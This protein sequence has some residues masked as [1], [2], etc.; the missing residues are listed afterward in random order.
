MRFLVPVGGVVDAYG[1]ITAPNHKGIPA[2]IKAGLPWAADVGCLDGPAYVKRINWQALIPWLKTMEPYRAQ[3]LFIA[4]GDIVADAAATLEAYEEVTRYFGHWPAAYVIQNG[5]ENL[6]IPDDC[7][8]VFLGGDTEYK[9]SMTAVSVIKRAQ[10]MG[11]HI[12]IGRVNWARRY[13]L[14]NVLNGSEF[15]TCDGT[16]TRYDGIEK[17]MAAWQAYEAQRPLITI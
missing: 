15:F 5:A 2:G 3:C 11:K 17:T 12:H 7:S 14:F 16:R 13:D 10:A 4:G 8:A 9:E 6:P 1:V